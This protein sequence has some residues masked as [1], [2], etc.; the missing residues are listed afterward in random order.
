MEEYEFARKIEDE[1]NNFVG[2]FDIIHM[3]LAKRTNSILITRD[4]NLIETAR[5]YR[6]KV[7]RPEE[8]L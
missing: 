3:L 7:A 8:F 4:R 6:V 5:K 2:F 1:I